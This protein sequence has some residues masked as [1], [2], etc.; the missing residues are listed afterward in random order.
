MIK[1]NWEGLSV[2]NG[3]PVFTQRFKDIKLLAESYQTYKS[4]ETE[5]LVFDAI[6]LALANA[7]SQ[8]L[9]SDEEQF[10]KYHAY[11]NRISSKANVSWN[12][13]YSSGETQREIVGAMLDKKYTKITISKAG[14]ITIKYSMPKNVILK[15][16]PKSKATFVPV[17]RLDKRFKGKIPKN[18]AVSALEQWFRRK[19]IK[20]GNVKDK[21]RFKRQAFITYNAWAKHSKPMIMNDRALRISLNN[22]AISLYSHHLE[23]EFRTISK[24]MSKDLVSKIFKNG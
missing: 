1:Y 15:L 9:P 5:K 3:V 22:R 24:S 16:F 19:N 10:R 6:H 23:K 20:F 4:P 12:V 18:K 21:D 8:L 17:S 14:N 7:S 11:V 2:K 13:G